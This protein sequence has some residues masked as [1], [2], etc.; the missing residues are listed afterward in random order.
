MLNSEAKRFINNY[1][2]ENNLLCSF[3]TVTNF[4]EDVARR[5][6][7]RC[8]ALTEKEVKETCRLV[9]CLNNIKKEFWYVFHDAEQ[10]A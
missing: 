1:A 2:S 10:L 9:S 3:N 6:D 4:L 8:L 5:N 7:V